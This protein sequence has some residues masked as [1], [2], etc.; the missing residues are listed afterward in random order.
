MTLTGSQL[1]SLFLGQLAFGAVLVIAVAVALKGDFI[2]LLDEG[3]SK[4]VV[5]IVTIFF[6]C[7]IT[8]NLT[9]LKIL[10]P[11]AA[12]AI[13]GGVLGYVFGTRSGEKPGGDGDKSTV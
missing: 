10:D 2:K 4:I 11:S 7:S 12:A 5:Q 8:G 6:V 3:R 9:L 13:F 1:T